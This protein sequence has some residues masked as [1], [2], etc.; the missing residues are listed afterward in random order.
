VDPAGRVTDAALDSTGPSRYFADLSLKAARQWVFTAPVADGRS[1]P[2]V[3]KI[4]F[5][6]TQSGVQLSSEQV[7]P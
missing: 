5:N 2:S 6:Y 7:T 1:A 3:W 4:Q